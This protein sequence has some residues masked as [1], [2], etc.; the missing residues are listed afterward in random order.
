MYSF[1][2]SSAT[3]K[4]VGVARLPHT[5]EF[6]PGIAFGPRDKTAT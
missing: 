6:S 3:H 2:V 5:W 4:D 1:L